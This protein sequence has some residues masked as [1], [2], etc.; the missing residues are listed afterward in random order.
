MR[1]ERC[2]ALAVHVNPDTDA[3]GAA[4]GML[5]LFGQLGI[6][7]Y[8]HVAE[9]VRLPLEE[10]LLPAGTVVRGL[11]DTQT[12]LYA[13]DCGNLSRAALPV[14]RWEG[15]VVNIDHHRDNSGFGDLVLLRVEASSTCEIVCDIARALALEPGPQAAAAL[16]AGLSFDSGHFR[17]SNTTAQ[18]FVCAAW[19]RGLGVDVTAVHRQLYEQRSQGALRLWARIVGAAEA[20]AGGRVMIATVTLN[21]YA[22]AGAHEDETEGIIETLRAVSGVEAAVLVKEQTEG[23]RVRVSLRSGD[24]DVSAI[25]ALRGGG[26]HRLAAGF[27]SDDSPQE[28][29]AWLSSELARRLSTASC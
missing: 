26:G 11:P 9:G 18:T 25:A 7:A 3:I 5:D 16:Y 10:Y 2:A 29:T 28:V 4:A 22:V 27:S 14:D 6:A 1:S 20:E 23:A 12:P 17:H 13:L 24:L 19:L 21:D 15:L 8:L